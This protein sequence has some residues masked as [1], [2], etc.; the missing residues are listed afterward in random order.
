MTDEQKLNHL[1]DFIGIWLDWR[2]SKSGRV[3]QF[4]YFYTTLGI[5]LD[6]SML[7]DEHEPTFEEH[8]QLM[9]KI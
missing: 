5:I 9:G 8:L 7:N 2:L 3:N 6:S 1:K 4:W